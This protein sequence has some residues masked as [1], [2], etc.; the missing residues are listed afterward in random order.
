EIRHCY[1]A[2]SRRERRAR[3][4]DEWIAI[5]RVGTAL[6]GF[7]SG[8]LTLPIVYLFNDFHV[9][10]FNRPLAPARLTYLCD[11]RS[12]RKRPAP[13]RSLSPSFQPN[14]DVSCRI[15]YV[16]DRSAQFDRLAVALPLVTQTCARRLPNVP[17]RS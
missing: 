4:L 15:Q 7:P 5:E 12:T 13:R 9:D 10:H 1:R 11:S 16:A 14:S 17:V 8:V 2:A 3:V 6:F